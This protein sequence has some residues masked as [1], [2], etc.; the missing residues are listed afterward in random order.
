M[1]KK[2]DE[3]QKILVGTVLSVGVAIMATQVLL[4]FVNRQKG[5]GVVIAPAAP[6][7]P[8]PPAPVQGQV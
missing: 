7:P 3:G 4:Y 6:S 2:L 8:S 5:S 1:F